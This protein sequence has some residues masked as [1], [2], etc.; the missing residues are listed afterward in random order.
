VA[1]GL[2]G[3]L[4][5]GAAPAHRFGLAVHDAVDLGGIQHRAA[6][7]LVAGLRP[8]LALAGPTLCPLA[9]AW[10]I[11]G[12]RLGRMARVQVDPML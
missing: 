5:G 1:L 12:R 9:C 10:S 3:Q 7:T 8:A 4:H 11:R 2:V 6:V